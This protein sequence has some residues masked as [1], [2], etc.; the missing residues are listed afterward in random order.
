MAS[1]AAYVKKNVSEVGQVHALATLY[2]IGDL[3]A[4]DARSAF[5]SCLNGDRFRLAAHVLS[6][7]ETANWGT[8]DKSHWYHT[9]LEHPRYHAAAPLKFQAALTIADW[10]DLDFQGAFSGLT[11]ASEGIPE[12]VDALLSSVKQRPLD[13]IIRVAS[14]DDDHGTEERRAVQADV[15]QALIRLAIQR[16][17][18][19][20]KLFEILNGLATSQRMLGR[21][22]G[23]NTAIFV[24]RGLTFSRLIESESLSAD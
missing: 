17:D 20:R 3:T 16:G 13:Q 18:D 9:V 7:R 23:S 12:I 21:L 6:I 24:S 11:N 14:P 2:G 22:L 15:V 8:S 1:S 5:M 19:E 4:E 10:S